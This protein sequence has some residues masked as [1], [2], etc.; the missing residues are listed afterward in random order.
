MF[1]VAGTELK[2]IEKN[3]MLADCLTKIGA[4]RGYLLA[5]VAT[6]TW[7]DQITEDAMKMKEKIRQGRHGRAEAARQ[8]KHQKKL[9][10]Q[11]VEL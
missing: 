6:N 3:M 8:A 11:K 7:S 4:E 5:A 9:E 10:D 2:W 1:A